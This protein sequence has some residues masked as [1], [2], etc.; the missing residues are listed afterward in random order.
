MEQ[1]LELL[2]VERGRTGQLWDVRSGQP[3]R[4]VATAPE[5]LCDL[6]LEKQHVAFQLLQGLWDP[7]ADTERG[8]AIR[9]VI[10]HKEGLISILLE[11]AI[12]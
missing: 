8:D 6:A 9:S 2:R 5:H 3:V 12:M 11:P 10:R 1:T 7:E 4:V